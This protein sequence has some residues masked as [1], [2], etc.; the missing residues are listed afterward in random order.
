MPWCASASSRHLQSN[1]WFRGSTD[2]KSCTPRLT[3]RSTR[4]RSLPSFAGTMRS[5]LS[6]GRTRIGHGHGRRHGLFDVRV[7]PALTP[8]LLATGPALAS[9]ADLD[10]HTLLHDYDRTYWASWFRAAG[11][12]ERA[13]QRGPI[14]AGGGQDIQAAKLGLGIALANPVLNCEDLRSGLLVR[15]FDIEVLVGAYWLVAPGFESL[16]RPASV[17]ADWIREKLAAET[18][19]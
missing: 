10:R 8:D 19:A 3:C 12:P 13:S 6:A 17:F 5:W 9:P 16:S 14:Y 1:G 11:L 2:F 7:A 15:P 18:Q 4:L